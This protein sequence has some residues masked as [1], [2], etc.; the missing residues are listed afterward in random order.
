MKKFLVFISFIILVWLGATF[1]IST[2]TKDYLLKYIRYEDKFQ[3]SFKLKSFKRGFFVSTAKIEMSLKNKNIYLKDPI[4]LDYKIYNGPIIFDDGFNFGFN[5]I[6]ST[7]KISEILKD[8]SKFLKLVKDDVIVDLKVIISFDKILNY[9]L[10]TNNII[11]KDK[12]ADI[13]ISPIQITSKINPENMVGKVTVFDKKITSIFDKN[14]I[15]LQNV[16]FFIDIKEFLDTETALGD[17]FLNIDKFILTDDLTHT[18]IKA[19]LDLKT[20][21]NKDENF[22]N[23][24]FETT[25]N[26]HDNT[27]INNKKLQFKKIYFKYSFNNIDLNSF[28]T[29]NKKI[30]KIQRENITLSNKLKEVKDDQE[31]LIIF[32]KYA[33]LRQDAQKAYQEFFKTAFIKD[34]TNLNFTL[35][36][37]KNN[38]IN[39]YILYVGK[40]FQIQNMKKD[41]YKVFDFK[42]KVKITKK[43]A[44]VVFKNP[45]EKFFLGLEKGFIKENKNDYTIDIEKN[46]PKLF[47]NKKD[48]SELLKTI[49]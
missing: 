43:F 21:I 28:L 16:K 42:L 27:K 3:N 14:K 9:K 46:G 38:F 37:D 47:I 44:K 5:K 12:K 39:F 8:K 31:A 2:Q 7:I 15:T 26:L 36:A 6:V 29:L 40:N 23:I 35:K 19:N 49:N 13:T 4:V 34:K 24:I 20:S 48:R 41:F 30:K 18:Y 11:I 33:K 22:L 32:Q 25:L 45:E 17:F 10:T 1:Y